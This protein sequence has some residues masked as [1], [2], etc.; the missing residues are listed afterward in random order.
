MTT[1]PTDAISRLS[2]Y[3]ASPQNVPYTM[4]GENGYG[5]VTQWPA[6]MQDTATVANWIAGLTLTL[7]VSPDNSAKQII[8]LTQ[9]EYDDLVDAGEI[10]PD[11][12]YAIRGN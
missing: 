3:N 12:L 7:V 6:A 9:G 4:V 8:V 11:T 10:Q 5:Y 1:I 2:Q